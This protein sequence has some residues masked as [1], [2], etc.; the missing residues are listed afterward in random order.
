MKAFINS[1]EIQICNALVFTA[2]FQKKTTANYTIAKFDGSAKLKIEFDKKV[3]SVEVR[4]LRYDFHKDITGDRTV[5][6][7]LT[8]NCNISVEINGS[9]ED[10]LLFYGGMS[11]NVDK[12]NYNNII[13]F[14]SGEHFADVIKIEDDNT[15]VYLEDGAVVNGK[16]DA[17]NRE[18]IAIDGYGTLT[19][20]NYTKGS[21]RDTSIH[22]RYC[23]NIEIKNILIK[24]SCN[25]HVNVWGCENIR[26]DNV[27]LLSYRPNTD[28]FDIC[29]SRNV[30][31]ENC[32]TR[33][34][35]DS[36]VVKGV[37]TG[38]VENVVFRNCV[39]WN[40]FARPMEL[41]VSIRADKM[42]NVR[43]ENID[44]IHS[45][46]G[47]PIVGIHHGDRAEIYDIHF[48]NINIESTPGA[49][50]VDL[51][52]TDSAWNHD[53][54]KGKIHDVYFKNI[55][56]IG[57]RNMDVLPYHS[58]LQGY[59]KENNIE[60]VTFE[61]IRIMGKCARN[62]KE[63]GI[64]IRDFVSD[65]K[66]IPGEEPFIEQ[67]KTSIQVESR[68]LSD[69]GTY[70]ANICVTLE[71]TSNVAKQGEFR[72]EIT[73][74][75]KCSYDGLISYNLNPKEVKEI[76]KTAVMPAGK[77]AFRLKS[78]NPDILGSMAY[79]N[80]DLVLSDRFSESAKYSFCDNYGHTYNDVRFA[81]KK[82]LLLIESELLKEYDFTIYACMPAD[83]FEGEML[84][85]VEDTNSG[86]APALT[87]GKNDEVFEA[88]QIGCPEE[89]TYVFKN[90][91]KVKE[92]RK[93][94]ILDNLTGISYVPF[95][96]LGIPA[97]ADNFWMELAIE[98]GHKKR[99]PLTMF[100]SQ[101][102]E[103]SA[104]MFVNVVRKKD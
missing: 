28:G 68:C 11:H 60:K 63:L 1:R 4:P 74:D 77:Y 54:K 61:N 78:S 97:D 81:L 95:S 96:M 56:Y 71:N 39:L 37:D 36:L 48:E 7:D 44:V 80:L 69:I 2:P 99:Y 73:P 42:H 90:Q 40:D 72:L 83:H 38:D 88:A 67:I 10:C 94:K 101:I 91:P 31:V 57:D 55:N 93:V 76:R 17:E 65:V 49:Q 20:Q 12:N 82:D 79:I 50:L 3:E 18:N 64:D 85:S 92:I 34:W 70:N 62:M 100:G 47:Y 14:D 75:K 98:C 22:L 8:Q 87:L 58:R 23:K 33:L 45:V 89:I 19:M 52:I 43:F 35:D 41:G 103:E 5:E 86:I 6:I 84:F 104:H 21:P 24:D 51:R 53:T 29:G 32:I 26:I 46:T 30:L 102:P 15:L 16:I 66:V 9:A 13:Y 27:K 25:W 59:S